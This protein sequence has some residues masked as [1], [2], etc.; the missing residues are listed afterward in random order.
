MKPMNSASSLSDREKMR[1]NPLRAAEQS[2]DL[3][4]ALVHPAVVL[5]GIEPGLGRRHDWDEAQFE[6]EL[7]RFDA[8]VG[9]VHEQVQRAVGWPEAGRQLPAHGPVVSLTRRQRER[10]GRSSIRG[11][12]MNLGGPA[13]S[14]LA[15]GLRAVSF[16]AP[17]PS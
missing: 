16:S 6:C 5:P 15:D 3:V 4:A 1:R 2:L 13:A 12:Q 7:A 11:N 17:V 9:A 14:R 10:Y 8:R